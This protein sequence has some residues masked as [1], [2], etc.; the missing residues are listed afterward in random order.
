[1]VFLVLMA[2]AGVV[3]LAFMLESGHTEFEK[4]Q[5]GVDGDGLLRGSD[6]EL[7]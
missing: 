5:R 1:M 2:V 3:I 7:P 4:L 6:R